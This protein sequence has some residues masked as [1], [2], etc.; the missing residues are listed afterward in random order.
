MYR[1][2]CFFCASWV[3]YL[4]LISK[5][6]YRES[7]TC[8]TDYYSI[9]SAFIHIKVLRQNLSFYFHCGFHVFI[10]KTDS[11]VSNN[12]SRYKLFHSL[13][14]LHLCLFAGIVSLANLWRLFCLQED[15]L[16][17]SFPGSHWWTTSSV[18]YLAVFMELRAS[19]ESFTTKMLIVF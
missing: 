3:N 12:A 5:Y 9:D 13:I 10:N 16:A 8:W 11:I 1:N 18:I 2:L 17:V 14:W 15:S 19:S 4:F 6:C 7:L